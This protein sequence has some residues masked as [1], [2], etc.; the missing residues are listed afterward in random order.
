MECVRDE[1]GPSG[2]AATG[3]AADDCPAPWL[4][5]VEGATAGG[6]AGDP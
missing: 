6:R 2:T 3:A 1:G 5:L 4:A